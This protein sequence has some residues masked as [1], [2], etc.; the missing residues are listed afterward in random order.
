MSLRRVVIENA[1]NAIPMR[2][3]PYLNAI[4]YNYM[5]L[6]KIKLNL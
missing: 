2:R 4:R 5:D 1:Q 6:N 3:T